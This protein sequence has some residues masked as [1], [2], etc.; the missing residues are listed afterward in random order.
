MIVATIQGLSWVLHLSV[1]DFKSAGPGVGSPEMTAVWWEVGQKMKLE[2]G[3]A[4]HCRDPKS[5]PRCLDSVNQWDLGAL[6]QVGLSLCRPS[7]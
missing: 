3:R 1:L 4:R 7:V 5:C 6:C 2:R